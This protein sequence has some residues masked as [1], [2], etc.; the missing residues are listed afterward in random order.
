MIGEKIKELRMSLKLS[1]TELGNLLNLKQPDVS[2]LEN[3][4]LK[5]IDSELLY[6]IS[7]TLNVSMDSFFETN[8]TFRISKDK[9][10]NLTS[11]QKTTIILKIL[12]ILQ[13]K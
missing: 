1:Q 7:K 10:E 4:G 12:D 13:G 5:S 8:E 11:E 3:G 6:R 2:K 9:I